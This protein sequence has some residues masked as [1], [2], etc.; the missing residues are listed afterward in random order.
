LNGTT[1]AINTYTNLFDPRFAFSG[2][3]F[4]RIW[5]K[6]GNFLY[7]FKILPRHGCISLNQQFTS[8]MENNFAGKY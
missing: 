6:G 3:T 2:A 8:A 1:I 5:S 4:L 7:T